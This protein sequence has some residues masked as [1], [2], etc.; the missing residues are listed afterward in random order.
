MLSSPSPR[1]TP[2]AVQIESRRLPRVY[3]VYHPTADQDLAAVESWAAGLDGL[4][5]F[6]RQGLFTPNS[7]S[8]PSGPS[9]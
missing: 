6:G 1:Q 8:G 7:I 5:T 4:I 9:Q 2:A 3:P